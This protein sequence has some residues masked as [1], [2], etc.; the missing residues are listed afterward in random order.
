MKHAQEYNDYWNKKRTHSGEGM[1]NMTPNEKLLEQG[2]YQANRILNFQVLYL[3]AHFN[4]LQT[5]LEYFFFQR[6][7]RKLSESGAIHDRKTQIDLLTQY[8]HLRLYAQ[9]VLTYYHYFSN[10]IFYSTAA[11]RLSYERRRFRGRL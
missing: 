5:H 1:N 7:L 2:F 6:D 11:L 4:N 10:D 9:N 3:D 8:P